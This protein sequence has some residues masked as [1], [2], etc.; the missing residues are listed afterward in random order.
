MQVQPILHEFMKSHHS[1][2]TTP[3]HSH[4]QFTTLIV[5][6]ASYTAIIHEDKENERKRNGNG[7]DEFAARKPN[8]SRS[9]SKVHDLLFFIFQP[10]T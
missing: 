4:V 9:S 2:T 3:T 7:V 10:C 8:S 5:S 1:L 6:R